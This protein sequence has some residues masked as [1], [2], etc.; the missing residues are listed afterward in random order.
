M[1]RFGQAYNFWFRGPSSRVRGKL[2][3][4]GREIAS[5]NTARREKKSTGKREYKKGSSR[6][7]FM[8]ERRVGYGN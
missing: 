8:R 3:T 4:Y 1:E 5:T 7:R 2:V 6:R